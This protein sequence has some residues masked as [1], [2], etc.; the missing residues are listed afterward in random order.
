MAHC[1]SSGWRRGALRTRGFCQIMPML[2]SPPSLFSSFSSFLSFFYL[3]LSLSFSFPPCLHWRAGAHTCIVHTCLSIKRTGPIRTRERREN[4]FPHTQRLAGPPGATMNPA[5]PMTKTSSEGIRRRFPW[6]RVS[7]F[8]WDWTTT[9]SR[10]QHG[11]A[12]VGGLHSH[13]G[14]TADRIEPVKNSVS[15]RDIIDGRMLCAG[16]L[17]GG[18]G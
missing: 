14:S 13:G 7:L 2:P 6:T 5:R 9:E 4:I 17:R 8:S 11:E 3:Y 18:R 16:T 12:H 1:L 15:V 10:S